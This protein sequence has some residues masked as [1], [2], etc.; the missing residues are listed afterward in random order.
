M[1]P[2]ANNSIN[3]E[4]AK[5]EDAEEL[6]ELE[7]QLFDDLDTFGPS[8]LRQ[9]I[10]VGWMLL[11]R[12]S[13][14]IVGYALVRPGPMNDLMKLG[15]RPEYQRTGIAKKLLQKVREAHGRVMLFVR[16]QNTPAFDLY[17]KTGFC[18]IGER[19]ESWLMVG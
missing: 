10:A 12:Q 11:A 17:R 8:T 15:V 18:I 6:A 19:E 7:L 2:E 1:A 16:K 13:G 3:F 9:E 5:V 14:I 4:L